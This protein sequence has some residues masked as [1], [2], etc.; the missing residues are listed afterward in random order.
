MGETSDQIERHIEETRSE[1]GQDLSELQQKVKRATNLRAQLQQHPMAG[2][3]I[4]FVG[5]F[6]I[7][8]LG[9]RSRYSERWSEPEWEEEPEP[10]NK[11]PKTNVQTRRVFD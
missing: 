6:A 2:L 11:S 10:I 3:G 9:A 5:G 1:L 8:M 7:A 4:A